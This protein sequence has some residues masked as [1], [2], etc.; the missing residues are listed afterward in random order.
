MRDAAAF[1]ETLRYF[2]WKEEGD[3]EEVG[4]DIHKATYSWAESGSLGKGPQRNASD[5]Q[6][7]T[8]TKREGRW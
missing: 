4:G 3:L 5:T 1:F 2:W 7:H 6:A 8:E